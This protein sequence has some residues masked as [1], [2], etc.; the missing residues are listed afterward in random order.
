M[1]NI[2][3]TLLAFLFCL[4]VFSQNEISIE[5]LIDSIDWEDCSESDLIYIFKDNIIQRENDESFDGNNVSRYSLKGVKIGQY[6][7]STHIVVNKFNRK[8][9]RISM[10]I[11]DNEDDL[12]KP[13]TIARNLEDIV[14]RIFGNTYQETI[15][16]FSSSYY[17]FEK[18]SYEYIWETD[19]YDLYCGA[20][21]FVDRTGAAVTIEKDI[22]YK[23]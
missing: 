13:E 17:N 23:K 4:P 20:T 16:H 14:K 6:S 7:T 15:D 18:T 2:I 22:S 19:K 12:K 10:L 9:V 21:I 8:V 5:T 1:K 11:D 3:F